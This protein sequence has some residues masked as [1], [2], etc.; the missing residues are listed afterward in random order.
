MGIRNR[1][2]ICSLKWSAAH[3]LRPQSKAVDRGRLG[4]REALRRP[5]SFSLISFA[6]LSL[7]L[8]ETRAGTGR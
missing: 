6:A 2:G 8:V 4:Y 5:H 7:L 3:H 1:A